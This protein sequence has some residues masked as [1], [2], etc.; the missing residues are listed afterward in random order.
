MSNF[1]DIEMLTTL[2]EIMEF[3]KE[4][5]PVFYKAWLPTINESRQK[6]ISDA[7]II[8]EFSETCKILYG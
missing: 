3:A 6:G 7:V 1:D 2:D 5:N 4:N 8:K